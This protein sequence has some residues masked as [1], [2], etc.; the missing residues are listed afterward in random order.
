MYIARAYGLNTELVDVESV[1][2]LK[3]PQGTLFGRNTSAGAVLIQA[4]NPRY[5]EISGKLSATYGR[6]DERT[7]QAVLN[8]G[9]SDSLA[10][11]GALWYQKRDGYK[12]DVNT[13]AKYERS[14][15]RRVGKECVS[16]CRSRWSPDH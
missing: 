10:V 13:G 2:V 4:A 6:F 1:Q 8:L 5:G 7:G 9:L 3:G 16:T 15:E 14:E 12:T 11:R